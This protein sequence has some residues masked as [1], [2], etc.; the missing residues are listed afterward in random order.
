MQPIRIDETNAA[1]IEVQFTTV[2]SANLQQR[3][4][5]T[6]LA[7]TSITAYIKRAGV[8]AAVAG[9]GTFTACDDTN[10]AG[11]R[12]YAPSAADRVAG[13]ALLIFKDAGG[14]ME[15]REV[16]VMFVNADPYAPAYYGSVVAG[17]LT[18]N[19]F[20]TNLTQTTTDAVKDAL[21][22]FLS[23]PNAGAVKPIGGFTGTGTVGTV[24][25]K[26]GYTLPATPTAGDKFRIITH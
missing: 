25:L 24:T 20:T 3:L 21:I 6:D 23:G 10:A 13:P 4:K 26:S 12:G 14:V 1:L 17:S 16:P 5:S 18:T 7:N 11:A 19:V 9:T 15:P 2:S 8:A 22:E